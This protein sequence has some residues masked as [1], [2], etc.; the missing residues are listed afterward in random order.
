MT[1]GKRLFTHYCFQGTNVDEVIEKRSGKSAVV[2]TAAPLESLS[3]K[4][5]PEIKFKDK[6]SAAAAAADPAKGNSIKPAAA[7]PEI[8]RA[9][10][11]QRATR[12]EMMA[13]LLRGNQS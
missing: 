10:P 9:T 2:E 12:K 5:C 11:A 4:D 6:E 3:G 8:A 13:Q 1:S 7:A